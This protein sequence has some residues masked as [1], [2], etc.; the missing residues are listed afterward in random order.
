ME[1]SETK[2]AAVFGEFLTIMRSVLLWRYALTFNAVIHKNIH[3]GSCL[4]PVRAFSSPNYC[5]YF[6]K[7]YNFEALHPVD[8]ATLATF[9]FFSPHF[10]LR[11]KLLTFSITHTG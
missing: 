4:T 9:L 3:F 2:S 1:W 11:I 6:K 7:S 10:L 5:I 8:D